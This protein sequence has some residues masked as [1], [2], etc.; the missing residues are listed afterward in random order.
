MN[1][2]AEQQAAQAPS[3]QLVY[4]YDIDVTD[5]SSAHTIGISACPTGSK[6]LD[7]GCFDGSVA[8]VLKERGCSVVGID[9]HEVALESARKICNFVALI[10]LNIEP[11]AALKD[12]VSEFGLFDVV[13]ALDVLEHV[14]DPTRVLRALVETCLAPHGRVVVSLPNVAHGSVRLALLQGRFDYQDFGLLD[15]SHVKF[16]TEASVGKLF[17]DSGLTVIAETE[18]TRGLEETEVR[19]SPKDFDPSLIESLDSDPTSHVYQF[20]RVAVKEDAPGAVRVDLAAVMTEKHKAK[21]VQRD[22]RWAAELTANRQQ[23]EALHRDHETALREYESTMRSSEIRIRDLAEM[24]QNSET[25]RR[26]EREQLV[27]DGMKLRAE[28]A[29]MLDSETWKFGRLLTLPLRK[30][31]GEGR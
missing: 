18:T 23:W 15:Q 26:I 3:E 25:Q 24:L 14:Q 29:L 4:Q 31:R 19:V 10:D 12:L 21:L 1:G 7:V 6:V 30:L 11:E 2:D 13:M 16:F 9:V 5:A 17:A 28:L 22:E 8:K 20:I 27:T